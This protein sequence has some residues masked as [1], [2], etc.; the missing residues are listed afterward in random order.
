MKISIQSDKN[1]RLY[2]VE[3]PSVLDIS[4]LSI[5]EL[6]F[7]TLIDEDGRERKIS[8]CFLADG[9]SLLIEK[10]IVRFHHN[11]IQK[12]NQIFR[13]GIQ[14]KGFVIQKHVIAEIMRPVSPKISIANSISGEIK[15]PMSGKVISVYVK[16]NS[17]VKEGDTLVIIEAMKMENRIVAEIDGLI[18]NIRVIPGA[19]ISSGDILLNIV[20]KI[21]G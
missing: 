16:D 6:F 13:F 2:Q 12:K 7:V 8:T 17:I 20:P 5:G 21:Q 15:S 19:S 4:H 9:R 3:I 11:F 18:S 10:K 1:S 14:D